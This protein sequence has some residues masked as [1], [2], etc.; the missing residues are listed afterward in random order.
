MLVLF[1]YLY[2]PTNNTTNVLNDSTS[3]SIISTR[4]QRGHIFILVGQSNMA[5][6][7]G[8]GWFCSSRMLSKSINSYIKFR[9]NMEKCNEYLH[10]DIDS[11]K[12]CGIGPGMVS[13]NKILNKYL[14]MA[15]TRWLL[16]LVSCLVQWEKLLLAIVTQV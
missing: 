3:V 14:V 10:L 5:G 1:L 12:T 15:T 9:I 11:N 16:T 7:D 6:R 8:L 2:S 13:A 4:N